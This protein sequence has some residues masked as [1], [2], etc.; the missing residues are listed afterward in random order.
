ML[1]FQLPTRINCHF[2][3]WRNFRFAALHDVGHALGLDETDNEAAVMNRTHGRFGE[4]GDP[5]LDE[6][7]VNGIRVGII[8]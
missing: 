8:Y 7:D 6:D 2:L 3:V 1:D 5:Q 4:S